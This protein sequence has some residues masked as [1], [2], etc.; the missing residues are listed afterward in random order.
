[1]THSGSDDEPDFPGLSEARSPRT[2]AAAGHARP[3]AKHHDGHRDRL[4]ERFSDAGARALADYELLELI[5]FRTIPRRDVKPIAKALIARLGSL[6]EV[7]NAP[8]RR[9]MEVPGVKDA[10]AL[11]IAIV[12]A[13]NQ[14]AMRSAVKSREVL[15]SWA[16]VLDYCKAAMAYETR[17]QFRILFLDRKNALIAD[18]VQGT[19]TVDHTPVYPR[20]VVKR[21]LE[22]S[23][24]AIILVHNH[25]SGDPT[26]SRADIDMTRTIVETAKPLGISVH[27]HIIIG[28]AGHASLKGLRLI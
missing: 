12:A 10:V 22:L 7:L 3:A 8:P 27:D 21:A 19:G 13:V 4:R 6:A 28:K 17:E 24:T 25:P 15:S 1:M 23:A 26:P 2:P 9:L 20:E 5:L 14:R 18:E 16:A 11:D